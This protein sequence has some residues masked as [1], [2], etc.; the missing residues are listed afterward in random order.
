MKISLKIFILQSYPFSVP[1]GGTLKNIIA[2]KILVG[3]L[4]L[5]IYTKFS[6]AKCLDHFKPKWYAYYLYVLNMYIV[7]RIKQFCK[8]ERGFKQISMRSD[9]NFD[10]V[11]SQKK[12]TRFQK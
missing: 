4:H 3:F 2:K 7:S 5:I 10:F 12:H 6:G 11:T 8:F 9:D 1:I